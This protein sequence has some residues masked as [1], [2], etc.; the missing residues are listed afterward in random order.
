[1]QDIYKCSNYTPNDNLNKTCNNQKRCILIEEQTCYE[2]N[3]V[4]DC[5]NCKFARLESWYLVCDFDGVVNKCVENC[6]NWKG[7]KQ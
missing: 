6:K 4:K 7:G 2:Y 3:N 1:M 5:T